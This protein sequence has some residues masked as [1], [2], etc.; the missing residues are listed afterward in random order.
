[1]DSVV[2]PEER[3]LFEKLKSI[4]AI[5]SQ[6]ETETGL[7]KLYIREI[8][9]NCLYHIHR[10]CISQTFIPLCVTDSLCPSIWK[11]LEAFTLGWSEA[12]DPIPD[13]FFVCLCL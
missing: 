6:T 10:Y 13:F 9:Y 11:S 2:S 12:T 5:V 3:L 7:N 1:M 4:R 8:L